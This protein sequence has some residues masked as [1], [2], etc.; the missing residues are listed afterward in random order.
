MNS[1]QAHLPGRPRIIAHRG[2]AAEQAQN[3][4]GA[5]RAC[6]GSGIDGVEF[7][8]HQARDGVLIIHHDAWLDRSTDGH[9]AVAVHTAQALAALKVRGAA[10]G[11]P[12]LDDALEALGT[13]PRLE[14]HLE[15]KTDHRG[16]VPDGLV[17][18]CLEAAAAR[19]LTDRLV[20]TSFRADDLECA[21][22]TCPGLRTA[23]A[24]QL[25]TSWMVGGLEVLVERGLRIPGCVISL[26]S[27]LA[28][29]NLEWLLEIAPGR[30]GVWNADD[31]DDLRFWLGQPVR[32]IITDRPTLALRLRDD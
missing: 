28:R 2:G 7:D 13:D 10:E 8:V 3:T 27:L 20:I 18:R 22:T 15:V 5:F 4:L 30:L 25:S 16:R 21:V 6:V 23:L 9:G 32:Q 24:I 14:L 1:D 19:G 12:R 11:P 26:E 31:E 17:Q 29:T